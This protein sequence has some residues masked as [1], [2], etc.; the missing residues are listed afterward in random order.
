MK[1]LFPGGRAGGG[2]VIR[3]EQ[4]YYHIPSCRT[5]VVFTRCRVKFVTPGD[6]FEYQER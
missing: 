1:G 2:L 4:K 3:E 5:A 6:P